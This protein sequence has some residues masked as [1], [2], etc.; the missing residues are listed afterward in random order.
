MASR[1]PLASNTRHKEVLVPHI[2]EK[3]G[4]K[5]Y[6]R[7]GVADVF[8]EFDDG[9][10][11]SQTKTHNFEDSR[12][13][14]KY[15]MTAFTMQ[16]L[17]DAFNKL[18]KGKA[19]DR[20]GIPTGGSKHRAY[21]YNKVIKRREEPTTNSSSQSSSDDSSPRWTPIN[22]LTLQASDQATQRPTTYSPSQQLRLKAAE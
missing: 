6:D 9:L 8:A 4:R 3:S 7:W 20:S 2:Q 19:P 18:S 21:L 14:P 12:S 10:R 16:E 17:G 13:Q 5:T 22:Q 11:R 1:T 15:T